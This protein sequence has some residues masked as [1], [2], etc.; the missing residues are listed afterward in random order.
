[1][2]VESKFISI[3]RKTLLHFVVAV[4]I[5]GIVT[6]V[7][8]D[9]LGPDRTITT[10]EVDTY[11]YGVWARDNNKVPYCLDKK[12]NKADDC[13]VCEW[14]RKPGNACGDATYWYT[15]GTKSEVVETT[16]NLPPATISDSLQNCN[17]NNGWCT[18][19]PSLSLN[20][21]EPL[22]GYSILAVEGSLNGQAF[23]CSGSACGVPLNEGNNDFTFW[24]LSSYGDS[25]EMGTLS[26][27]VDTVSPNVGLD[28]IGSNGTNSWYVS[29]AT[30]TATGSDSTSGLSRVLL[31]VNGGAWKAST[32][33]NDGI[34]IVDVQAEDNAGNV[35]TS[36]TTISVDT[37]T[38]SIDIS[39]T[40]T[41]GNNGWY[42]SD[43]QVTASASDL[44]SDIASLEVSTNSGAYQAYTSPVSFTDGYHTI[45]FKAT[46][47]AGNQTET[48]IQEF[49]VDATAPA[50]DLPAEWEVN[51]AITYKIQDDG[52][53]LSALRIVIED[54]D[55]KF[56]KVAWDEVVSGNKFRGE[57][58]WNGKFKDGTIAPPGEY[59]VWIKAKDQAGNERFGLGRVV[60]PQP[61]VFAL[62]QPATT[63]NQET[64]LPPQE[65]FDED[66]LPIANSSFTTPP[67]TSFGGSTTDPKEITQNSLSLA[68]GTASASTT[69]NSN[70]LWGT[71]AAAMVGAMMAYALDEKR[72]RKEQEANKLQEDYAKAAK[73][74]AA[75][76]Q[77]KI[78]GWLQ[79]QAT[80][81]AYL[82]EA[83]KQGATDTDIRELQ[84]QGATQGLGTAIGSATNLHQNLA[85]RNAAR[86]A[87]MEAKMIRHEMEE[88]AQQE[89][90]EAARLRALAEQ[91]DARQQALQDHRAREHDTSVADAWTQAQ[92]QPSFWENPLGWF[93]STPVYTEVVKPSVVQHVNAVIQAISSPRPQ[94]T[95][96]A[97]KL[98]V[99]VALDDD[100]PNPLE[101]LIEKGKELFNTAKEKWEVAKAEIGNDIKKIV[102][103][104]VLITAEFAYDYLYG[105][106]ARFFQEYPKAF[107]AVNTIVDPIN[108]AV[109]N[110]VNQD[111][112]TISWG[113]LTT[114][115]FFEVG[116]QAQSELYF[117]ADD[118][119]T[120]DLRVH[121]GVMQQRVIVL[122]GLM[123][124]DSSL[125]DPH[126]WEYDK[127]EFFAGL[128][129]GNIMTSFLGSYTTEIT[130]VTPNSDGSYTIS[131]RVSNQ[132]SWG[133][134]T[135]L[136][137]PDYPGGPHKSI[138][139]DK[140]RGEG[141]HFG[142]DFLQYWEWSETI[143][144][145]DTP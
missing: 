48:P 108:K 85:M 30:I 21:S 119:T 38:P 102:Q 29:P 141:I 12:G 88:D 40:G 57:I 13:V 73:L 74:N 22:S 133:S 134:G 94:P 125:P 138:I 49:Y 26:A 24:A 67:Q 25:S 9:Y 62:L 37:I 78:N 58:T 131:Y 31:S 16:V 69:T 142:G 52:S 44:T 93:R 97:G 65:L 6:P 60:V 120:L 101:K 33:L 72:K 51:D 42:S 50:I 111:P 121:E 105:P 10:S 126:F 84:A 122:Q 77:R 145:P 8:A 55:E 124:G 90:A 11:D 63:N 113:E 80:L 118:S 127:P 14:K 2:Q 23:A 19:S 70:I 86:D 112:Q 15:L 35:S 83:K 34:H 109:A 140:Y 59:L 56:D 53:G 1:M 20:G 87:R 41:T 110:V 89:A 106:S 132:T 96:G 95:Q 137:K 123:N 5:L 129:S 39:T 66:E 139:P 98:A 47:N 136:R 32:T 28:V 82:E 71:T 46:D 115:W 64:L 7:L 107:G 117:D 3:K 43:M 4:L 116:G 45:Q 17:L 75:E 61:T 36:S 135:R 103:D 91:E 18:T 144:L 92:E 54:E 130:S 27:K 104:V 100:P 81:N 114:M 143:T 128:L 79:G 68:T 76:E 99:P